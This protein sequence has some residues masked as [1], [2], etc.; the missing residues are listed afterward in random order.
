[1]WGDLIRDIRKGKG[2]TQQQLADILGTSRKQ[3][4]NWEHSKHIPQLYYQQKLSKWA[5]LPIKILFSQEEK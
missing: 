4:H 1:M 2:Q 5:R 3:V